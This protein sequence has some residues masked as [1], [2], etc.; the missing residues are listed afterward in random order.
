M[1]KVTYLGHSGFFVE[2]EDACFLFDYYKGE[3][4][5]ADRGK[6]LFVFVSHGHYDH[7]RKEI[8]SLRDQYDQVRCL[9]SS[10]IFVREAED[11]LSVKPNE[12]TEVLGCRIR[13]LRS[14]DE[15][16]AF[17]LKYRGR[18]IY[19]AGDLNW[20]HWEGEDEFNRDQERRYQHQMQLLAQELDGEPLNLACVPVD[21]RLEGDFLRG[22]LAFDAVVRAE[23][24]LPI[25]LWG[26]LSV[27]D[28]IREQVRPQLWERV[29]PLKERGR[30]L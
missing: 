24:I 15:G 26:D 18:T 9:I 5:E 30:V 12:E 11:I 22:L 25:H 17:L 23:H 7:Y 28:R 2:M 20:W 29:L 1:M 10:D 8:F 3:L 4:P 19:H 21:P 27:P 14:T 16:V 13:T 6:K